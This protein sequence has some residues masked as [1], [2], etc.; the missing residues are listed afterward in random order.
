MSVKGVKIPLWAELIFL[1]VSAG[2]LG[3]LAW[4]RGDLLSDVLHWKSLLLAPTFFTALALGAARWRYVLAGLGGH[5]SY[6]VALRAN[7]QSL[8][9]YFFL[10]LG[11]GAE[12][13]RAATIRT[14]TG[15]NVARV[16]ASV[17]LDRFAGLIRVGTIAVVLGVA[18]RPHLPAVPV[19]LVIV[20]ALAVITVIFA[21]IFARPLRAR[22][23]QLLSA[24]SELTAKQVAGMLGFSF[25]SSSFL[26]ITA[27]LAGQ[28][29]GVT[30]ALGV[31]FAFAA[32]AVTAMIPISLLGVTP[33]EVTGV[34]LYQGAGASVDQAFAI[35]AS[36]Y[37]MRLLMA[38]CGGLWI[39]FTRLNKSGGEPET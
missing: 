39:L 37:L 9:F 3:L 1:A 7:I 15:L 8:F 4:A 32:S 13:Y 20:I 31:A 6:G 14:A 11:A 38:A 34:V 2:L 27:I 17:I 30:D 19:W 28:L 12:V 18:D 25:A 29:Q 24:L 26:V 22:L 36:I 5:I 35:A 10:P 33:T 16:S 21:L 23:A